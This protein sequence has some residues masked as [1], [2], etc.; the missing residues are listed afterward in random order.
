MPSCD[1]AAKHLENH[2]IVIGWT[3]AAH[4]ADRHCK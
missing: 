1:R 2:A 3:K 4:R